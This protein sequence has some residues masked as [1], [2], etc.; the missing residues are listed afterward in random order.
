MDGMT[1]MRAF[2]INADFVEAAKKIAGYQDDFF[3]IHEYGAN[4][5][6]E[7]D[8]ILYCQIPKCACTAI[9]HALLGHKNTYPVHDHVFKNLLTIPV[10]ERKT[11]LDGVLKFVVVRNPYSRVLSAYLNK[12]SRENLEYMPDIWRDF[13]R[14]TVRYSMGGDVALDQSPSFSDFIKLVCETPVELMNEHWHPQTKM[15]MV[16]E[17]KYDFILRFEDLDIEWQRLADKAGLPVLP[18]NEEI[19]FPATKADD[20]LSDFYTDTLAKAVYEKF[21][22]DFAYFGYSRKLTF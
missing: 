5:I 20:R 11:F 12:F 13:S 21:I 2:E 14:Y 8:G 19:E 1:Y 15:A 9:K 10:E 6:L 17:I 18:S 7:P 22:D 3:Y 4:I 16:N